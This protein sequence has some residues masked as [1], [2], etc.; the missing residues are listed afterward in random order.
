VALAALQKP[1]SLSFLLPASL[2]IGDILFVFGS[3]EGFGQAVSV[4][5]PSLDGVMDAA[6][7]SI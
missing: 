5:P 1:R 3:G 2:R 4:E 7:C 6:S